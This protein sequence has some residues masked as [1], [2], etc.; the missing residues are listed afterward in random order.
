VVQ[1]VENVDLVEVDALPDSAR[2]TTGHGASGGFG[3][4][5]ADPSPVPTTAS[6]E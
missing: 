3:S 6:R 1:R 2:G 4:P 5:A